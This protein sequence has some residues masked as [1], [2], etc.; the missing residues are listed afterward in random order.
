MLAEETDLGDISIGVWENNSAASHFKA[1]EYQDD[2][3]A[4]IK[5]IIKT[6]FW[7]WAL[8]LA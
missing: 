1:Q 3:V 8:H 2:Y 5:Q 6:D 4:F 7:C